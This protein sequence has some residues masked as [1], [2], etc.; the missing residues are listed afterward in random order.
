[1]QATATCRPSV[2]ER[3][4]TLLATGTSVGVLWDGGRADLTGCHRV[5]PGGDVVLT[6]DGRTRFGAEAL[7]A[8]SA[9]QDLTVVL[10]FTDVI[11]VAVRDR[12]RARL[13]L[14]GWVSVGVPDSPGQIAGTNGTGDPGDNGGRARDD[15]GA[16]VPPGSVRLCVDVAEVVLE[17]DSGAWAVELDE[18]RDARPDCL[19]RVEAGQLL[20]LAS[21]HPGAITLLTRLIGDPLLAGARRVVPVTLDRYGVVMRVERA[22][23]H[24]DVR[25]PFRAPITRPAEAAAELRHLLAIATHRTT[26]SRFGGG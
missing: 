17:D 12:V 5:L 13:S 20:H 21:R 24:V 1:M 23:G 22:R 15:A 3:A 14:G 6:V 10:E 18:Y 26:C 7:S 19:A 8:V 2:G 25:L 4:R 11:A 9:G 16:A